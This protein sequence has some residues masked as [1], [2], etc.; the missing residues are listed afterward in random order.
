[1]K[2]TSLT[3]GRST[4]LRSTVSIAIASALLLSTAGCGPTGKRIATAPV[5]GKV[6]YKGAPVTTGTVMF[7]PTTGGPPATAEIQPDGTYSL[8][9]Y[10]PGD[11]AVLGDHT[12][13]VTAMDLPAGTPEDPVAAPTMLVP[14]EFGNPSTSGL[15]ATVV[16]GDNALDFNL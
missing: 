8:K 15:T 5:K 16:E 12:V 9:T 6:T 3:A 14:A 10:D 4:R 13:A 11:G 7:I 1:M 2:P